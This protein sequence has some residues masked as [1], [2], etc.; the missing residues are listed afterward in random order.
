[1]AKTNIFRKT[2][3]LKDTNK[4]KGKR[5]N[6]KRKAARSKVSLRER[7]GPRTLPKAGA[8]LLGRR[9]AWSLPPR[10]APGSGLRRPRARTSHPGCRACPGRR[11]GAGRPAPLGLAPDRGPHP[12]K[13]GASALRPGLAGGFRALREPSSLPPRRRP[14]LSGFHEDQGAKAQRGRRTY[15]RRCPASRTSLG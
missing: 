14:T 15:P 3:V 5:K 6:T 10:P 4:E 7:R 13:R 9:W 11:G 8:L 2:S 1:M 12:G